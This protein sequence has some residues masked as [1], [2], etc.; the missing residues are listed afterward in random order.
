MKKEKNFNLVVID[1]IQRRVKNILSP[2]SCTCRTHPKHTNPTRKIW[3]IH[4]RTK[5]TAKNPMSV[6]PKSPFVQNLK[7]SN[8]PTHTRKGH[9]YMQRNGSIWEPKYTCLDMILC[10]NI[11]AQNFYKIPNKTSTSFLSSI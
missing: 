3:P 10:I 8:L 1:Y 4:T 6:G 5:A 7:T 9:K 2:S 11:N